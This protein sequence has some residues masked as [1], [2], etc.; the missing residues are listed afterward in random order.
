MA[1]GDELRRLRRLRG[2]TQEALEERSGVNQG[3]I[4][5]LENGRQERTSLENINGFARALDVDPDVLL[6]AMGV[7]F[8]QRPPDERLPTPLELAGAI[9]FV[10]SLTGAHFQARV[11]R[12]RE[13]LSDDAFGRVCLRI[14]RA[15]GSNADAILGMA[16]DGIGGA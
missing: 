1:L 14:A 13:R 5:A 8:D 2:L 6:G 9:T 7:D 12:L 16:E 15:W 10:E 4:S 11:A 3:T